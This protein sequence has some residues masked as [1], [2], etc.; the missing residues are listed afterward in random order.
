MDEKKLYTTAE[1]VL[2]TGLGR[3]TVT[4]RAKQ[5]GF[6][7]NGF[8]YTED[9]VLA[10]VTLPMESHRK[11]EQNAIDLRARLNRRFEDEDIPMAIVAQK[12]GT[13][14][15]EYRSQKKKGGREGK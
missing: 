2:A 15:M 6:N 4:N 10:I 14:A 12:N 11:N 5:L 7:R 9:Q 3:G 1:I 13:F 8:G